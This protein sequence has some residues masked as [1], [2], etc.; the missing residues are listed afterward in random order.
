M[1][2]SS[3][4]S[5]A[6]A[7]M[8]AGLRLV[9]ALL[10]AGGSLRLAVVVMGVLAGVCAWATLIESRYGTPAAQFGIYQ[11]WWFAGLGWLLG[12][13]ILCA[14]LL[15][16]P[17]RRRH[18]GFLLAHLGILA[19]LAGCLL[20]RWFGA[21][22]Q[23]PVF[24]GRPTHTAYQDRQAFELQVFEGP[25]RA[26]APSEPSRSI[27]VPFRPGPFNWRDYPALGTFPWRLAA[28][29]RGVIYDQGDIRLEVLDYLGDSRRLGV[30]QVRLA[31]GRPGPTPGRFEWTGQVALQVTPAEGAHASLLRGGLGQR[32]WLGENRR[33]L[34]WMATSEA[35][36]DTFLH[37]L[38]EGEVGPLGQVVLRVRGETFR[39]D[40]AQ[41]RQQ[42]RQ[43]LGDTGLE[44]ELKEFN[45]WMLG[46][47]LAVFAP[48]RPAER[49]FLFAYLPYANQNAEQLGVCGAYWF[50]P[51]QLGDSAERETLDE[52]ALREAGIARVEIL[53][54]HDQRLYYRTVRAARVESA[55]AWP[56]PRG[57]S[58]LGGRITAFGDSPRPL[59]LQL[60]EFVPASKPQ[61][62]IEPLPFQK[63]K[64]RVTPRVELRLTVD[65]HESRF[66]LADRHS[67][68]PD[69]VHEVHSPK[70]RVRISLGYQSIDLGFE[71]FL[72]RFRQQLDPGSRQAA[73]Y[74]S[75]VDFYARA[76]P[77]A[78]G[79]R[80]TPRATSSPENERNDTEALAG[81][82]TTT[83]RSKGDNGA[84]DPGADASTSNHQA[85][86]GRP[87]ESAAPGEV[88]ARK[89]LVTLNTPVEL[90]DPRTGRVYRFFQTD[91]A[92][93]FRPG[94]PEYDELV[95]PE[96]ARD[97][98][99]L[100]RLTINYD[101]GRGL[102]YTGSTMIVLGIG[103]VY[104]LRRRRRGKA[105][106]GEE[107]PDE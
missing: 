97:E 84:D 106:E 4:A 21:R 107:T 89:V 39:F 94:S 14:I 5:G 79:Q 34:F 93:P 44:V 31:T 37:A 3:S 102:K 72:R 48:R 18:I 77:G 12:V 76:E 1:T 33:V 17:W 83:A 26:G 57:G 28:R 51:E 20:D 105:A 75:L 45:P 60:R 71:V 16:F 46:V 98:L 25:S 103:L 6:S 13:N 15:R 80:S 92:G 30:P 32:R 50:D 66:W 2:R 65:G 68:A 86:S 90:R 7:S 23:L 63:D 10:R 49:M 24:E 8:P 9:W 69:V 67:A 43:R 38:P 88:L 40:V 58:Q 54:G 36:T 96:D 35:Q 41:L 42:P 91:F 61:W 73:H 59:A 56:A 99:Y 78:S 95:D 74:S 104:W 52:S 87:S 100:S 81:R 64:R 62:R 47:Q 82:G 29:S 19:L 11:S 27:Y 101:P 53:Q 55:G 22:G 85:P 70:R